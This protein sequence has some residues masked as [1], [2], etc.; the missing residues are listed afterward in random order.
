[1][2]DEHQE[3]VEQQQREERE[4]RRWRSDSEEVR[5][6]RGAVIMRRAEREGQAGEAGTGLGKRKE[7]KECVI[8]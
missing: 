2:R 5:R 8:M 6:Q 4:R 3:L 1:M 7:K